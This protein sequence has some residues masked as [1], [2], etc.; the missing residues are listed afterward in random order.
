MVTLEDPGAPGQASGVQVLVTNKMGPRAHVPL[1]NLAERLRRETVAFLG[2]EEAGRTWPTA[3][4]MCYVCGPK[5]L[6][7]IFEREHPARAS[8]AQRAGCDAPP[9]LIQGAPCRMHKIRGFLESLT[10]EVGGSTPP[11]PIELTK[12]PHRTYLRG[13]AF[14]FTLHLLGLRLPCVA[15]SR[16][17]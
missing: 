3:G 6:P 7:N 13:G 8:F 11:R 2:G 15:F 16:A 10:I 9:R 14:C 12:A 17:R 5:K 1:H 4:Y